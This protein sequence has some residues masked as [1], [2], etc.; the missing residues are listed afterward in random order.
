V[1]SPG[2]SI[3]RA[4]SCGDNVTNTKLDCFYFDPTTGTGIDGD[5]DILVY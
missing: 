5:I 2:A 3:A 4:V 1:A